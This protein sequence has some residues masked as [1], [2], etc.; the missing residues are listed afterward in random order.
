VRALKLAGVCRTKRKH[1]STVLLIGARGA[2]VPK[3]PGPGVRSSLRTLLVPEQPA[4][5]FKAKTKPA[6]IV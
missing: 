5:N 2:N 1:V 3:V 6:S 4:L